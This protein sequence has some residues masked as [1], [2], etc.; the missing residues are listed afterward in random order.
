MT[1]PKGNSEFCFFETVNVARG[2]A[3]ENVEVEGKQ[4]SLFAV[5]PVIKCFVISPNSR[6]G[7]L[8][9]VGSQISRDFTEHDVITREAKV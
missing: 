5:E 2:E 6:I 1:C 7:C 3:E 4:N 8:A 9:R